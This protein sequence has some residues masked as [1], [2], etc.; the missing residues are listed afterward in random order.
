MITIDTSEFERALKAWEATGKDEADAVNLGMKTSLR[1]A[2]RESKA[3]TSSRSKIDTE[4]NEVVTGRNGKPAPRKILLVQSGKKRSGTRKQINSQIRVEAQ[5][6][7][8]ARKRTVG[9]L[10]V[11]IMKA[12]KEFGLF[13]KARVG[14]GWAAD[15]LGEKGKPSINP[16]SRATISVAKGM[17][18]KIDLQSAVRAASADM[19]RWAQNRLAERARKHSAR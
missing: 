16:T 19:L 5:R 17:E 7:L 10:L 14:K 1:I 13:Q 9:Y 12:G 11:A 8:N 15:S 18:T 3:E 6:K 4:L 2:H